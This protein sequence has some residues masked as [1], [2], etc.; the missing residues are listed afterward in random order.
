MT[1]FIT[2]QIAWSSVGIAAG[3]FALLTLVLVA[4]LIIARRFLVASE[5]G[6]ASCRE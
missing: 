4:I 3:F 2:T 5:I 1:L 6:R